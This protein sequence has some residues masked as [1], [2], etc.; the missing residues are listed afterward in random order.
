MGHHLTELWVPTWRAGPPQLS[1]SSSHACPNQRVLGFNFPLQQHPPLVKLCAVLV[2]GQTCWTLVCCCRHVNV[3]HI[4]SQ[5]AQH[6]QISHT[7][8]NTTN[9]LKKLTHD[10]NQPMMPT[11]RTSIGKKKNTTST[12]VELFDRMFKSQRTRLD[13]KGTMRRATQHGLCRWTQKNEKKEAPHQNMTRSV[14]SSMHDQC[15]QKTHTTITWRYDLQTFTA[16]LQTIMPH[17]S[18][19]EPVGTDTRS[20]QSPLLVKPCVALVCG[21]T[22]QLLRCDCGHVKIKSIASSTI[23]HYTDQMTHLVNN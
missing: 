18:E 1:Q 16:S 13:A 8:S 9:L 21:P 19:T 22:C 15:Q 2:C 5:P 23:L 3:D 6:K 4:F 14:G 7:A 17:L 12:G 10:S 11:P 20:S